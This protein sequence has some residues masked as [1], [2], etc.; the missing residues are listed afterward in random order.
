M[1]DKFLAVIGGG[2]AGM[3][4][5]W[6]GASIGAKVILLEK[7]SRLGRKMLIT[8]KGRCNVTNN[9]PVADL[10]KALVGNGK[11]LYGALSE[12]TAADTMSWFKESGVELKTER[13]KRVFPLSDKSSDIVDAMAKRLRDAG[14]FIKCE[15]EVKDIIIEDNTVTALKLQDRT[16]AVGGVIIATGGISYPATGSTGDGYKFA[17]KAGHTIKDTYPALVPLVVREKYISA[18]EGLS[19]RN[20]EI[21]LKEDNRLLGKDFG[22][23]VFTDFGLSGPVILSLSHLAGKHFLDN[24]QKSLS[25]SIN[26]KPALSEEQ[27]DQRLLRDFERYPKRGYKALLQ[28]LLPQKLIP[29]FIELSGIEPDKKGNQLSREDRKKILGLLRGFNFTVIGCRPISEAIVTAGG[30]NIK[31]ID[32]KT[33]ASKKIKGLYFAGEVMDIHGLTGGFNIQAALASGYRSGRAAAQY[34]RG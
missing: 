20:A 32:P 11:F 13:G 17:L 12:F 33:M 30:I 23:M 3:M 14:V 15:T 8:G 18:L 4:A 31:E 10:V 25:L 1:G 21:I 29:I 24:P 26:L 6:A 9:A 34:L 19:L 28:G 27:L 22:E 16:I 7:N 2:P 5:A